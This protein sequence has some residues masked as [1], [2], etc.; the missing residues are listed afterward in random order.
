MRIG[1]I[2]G[3]MQ[4]PISIMDLEAVS[5]Y[6]PPTE[7]RGQ[8]RRIGRPNV[9]VVN[10][11]LIA[12][13]PAGLEGTTNISAGAT[14]TASNDDLKIKTVSTAGFTTV[15]VAQAAYASGAALVTAVNAAL[16]GG[17]VSARA[18]LSDDGLHLVLYSLTNGTGSFLSVDTVGN[19][20][21][22]NNAVGLGAGGGSFTIPS[23][24][25]II[26]DTLP[27]GGPLDV[28][29]TNLR[30]NVGFGASDPQLS[31]FADSIA[32]RLIETDAAIKSFQVGMISGFRSS[33]YNPDPSRLP[34]LTPGAAISVVQDDGSTPFTAPLTVIS[35][36]VHNSP[37][38]GDITIT[39]TN[40]G[41]SE[42]LQTVVRVYS[43]DMSRSV[44]LYQKIIQ[45]TLTGG[46]QGSVAPTSIV[47]PASLL[48]SLGVTGSKVRVQYT[49]FASN[50]FT[51]T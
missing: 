16:S 29:E 22:F 13:I 39:G 6:N 30:S 28:S 46:T 43:S 11:A 26:T 14:I 34:A 33:S 48:S 47:I 17:G 44:K 9:D 15:L 35:G 10:A 27:V 38:G 5:Q 36:A 37:N 3:D 2:R 23:A 49:S 32:P 50:L 7:P 51:V 45:R 4:G 12:N 20:S 18:R 19:G 41:N 21:V 31:A 42:W 25:S 24:A 8:E 1:V 40:L